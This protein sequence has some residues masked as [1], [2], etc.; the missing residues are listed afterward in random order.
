MSS[1]SFSGLVSG[2]D[3]GS[4]VSQLVE[5]KRAPIYR[6]ESRKKGYQDQIG[7]LGILKTKLLAFQEMAQKLD[8]S[9]E[10]SSLSATS[11]DEDTLKVTA[12]DDAAPGSYVIRVESR[13]VAQKDMS[14][15]YDSRL[16]SVGSGILSFTVNGETT[17]LNLV[18][19]TSLEI[20]AREI[21]ENV[22]GVG[23]TVLYDGSATGGYRLVLSGA[24][25]GTDN[26]FSVDAS[27]MS[28]GITPIFT[29]HVEA[30]DAHL[31]VDGIAV[32]AGSN[33]P[34]DIIAGLTFD[35]LSAKPG[36][37]I[38]VDIGRDVEGISENVK[39]F[40]DAYNDLKQYMLDESAVGADLRNN[41]TMRSVGWRIESI[42]TSSLSNGVGSISSFYQIGITR[43]SDNLLE[44]N[45]EDF[46]DALSEDYGGVRDLFIERDGN[47]GKASLLDSAIDNITDSVDGLFKSS[48]SILNDKIK[49]ADL[50]IRRYER[51]IETYQT[52]LER[53]FTAMESLVSQLQ[54]QGSYLSSIWS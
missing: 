52:T 3:T 26:S 9:N 40:V 29:N 30:A 41:A 53:K 33:N 7:A 31:T 19:F 21:N 51:S 16:D 36:E 34:D 44:W 47:I 14:Q 46:A 2:M 8:S 25:A 5:L 15:G 42:M 49:N 54:A 35:L 50:S 32:V 4:I 10:F 43:G 37:D 39:A 6:L 20:L 1:V 11:S 48:T 23:A 38:Y 24:D 45:A 17:D 22:E 28:G 27:G 12:A 13:A 18:G